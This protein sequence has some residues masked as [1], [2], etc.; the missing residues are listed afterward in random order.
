VNLHLALFLWGFA[1]SWLGVWAAFDVRGSGSDPAGAASPLG[2][3]A[4]LTLGAGLWA[5]GIVFSLALGLPLRE[6]LDVWT[7]MLDALAGAGATWVTMAAVRRDGRW[8]T[9]LMALAIGAAIALP[10]A[11]GDADAG[12]LLHALTKFAAEAAVAGF[13]VWLG[14]LIASRVTNL[15]RGGCRI[16][17]ILAML[18]L[19]TALGLAELARVLGLPFAIAP[20][21][22]PLW[23]APDVR[24]EV[25]IAAL[26]VAALLFVVEFQVRHHQRMHWRS[27]RTLVEDALDLVLVLRPDGTIGYLSPSAD[28][29]LGS[30]AQALRDLPLRHLVHPDDVGHLPIPA[31][32]AA[33]AGGSRRVALR[34]VHAQDGWREFEGKAAAGGRSGEIVLH[35]V[36]VTERKQAVQALR[37]LAWRDELIL[38]SLGEGILGLDGQGAV[39]FANAAALAMLDL[40][41][42]EVV[43]RQVAAV[44]E[45]AA[46]EESFGLTVSAAVH[47]ALATG[48]AQRGH[49]VVLQRRGGAELALD[50]TV[51][52]MDAEGGVAGAVALFVDV[53]RRRRD[54]NEKRRISHQFL[55]ALDLLGDAV[56]VEDASHRI[57]YV[58][59]AA[60]ETLGLEVGDVNADGELLYGKLRIGSWQGIGIRPGHGTVADAVRL[61][62][63][64][65]PVERLIEV[66]GRGPLYCLVEAVPWLDGQGMPGVLYAVRDVTDIRRAEEER[67]R[68]RRIEALGVF[69]GGIAHDFNNILTIVLG[70]LALARADVAAGSES[71]GLLQS[72]EHACQQAAGLTR[73]LLTFS[74]GGAPVTRSIML[75]GLLEETANYVLQGSKAKVQV[76][77]PQDLWRVEADAGQIHQVIT[78]IVLNA[79]QAMPDGGLVELSAENVRIGA[80]DQPPMQPGSY[81]HV[82]IG[83]HGMGIEARDLEHIFEPYFTTKP[84]GHGLGLATCW[85][86]MR[87]H[88]GYI[89][90]ESSVGAG[91]F[92][93]LYL[94]RARARIELPVVPL[95][96][97]EQTR[98]VLLMDDEREILAVSG[99]M[100]RR[101][102]HRVTVARDGS[103]ALAACHE[104]QADDLPFD[105]AILDLTI[106]GG[107]GGREAAERLRRMDPHICLIASSGYSNDAVMGD[108]R[109]Y[110]FQGVLAKPY[111]REELEAAIEAAVRAGEARADVAWQEVGR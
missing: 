27:F 18:S 14:L 11:T 109:A 33:Q 82:A 48:A 34:L 50:F 44:M 16:R 61:G 49:D 105:V 69:A 19:G 97:P 6:G 45:A 8:A 38:R 102:G 89:H 3:P 17:R 81:V 110:G 106:P 58:N 62:Q 96:H 5:S 51:A 80:D 73:Q 60:R 10:H 54:E 63:S 72:A 40:P 76:R 26:L 71:E 24:A 68:V 15:A 37:R 32:L 83:D 2:V 77:L 41:E 98:R 52:P 88:G 59:H 100:L 85:S 103:E 47:A 101:M 111:R 43:G 67:L 56:T 90:A 28:R 4:A 74:R 35:L 30:P 13:I 79:M 7:L 65:G 78:N 94:P 36:D 23:Q 99:E 55:E 66:P 64:V 46:T 57:V 20:R 12:G 84:E 42:Y 93:H 31:A 104:A 75:G 95:G 39:T 53:S 21:I 87:R 70:N 107:M 92:F 25:A 86:I 29:L 1:M 91:T 22:L 9:L 108:H